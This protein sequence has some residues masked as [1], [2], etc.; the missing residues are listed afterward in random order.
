MSDFKR[1]TEWSPAYNHVAEGNGRHCM[2][3]LRARGLAE[4]GCINVGTSTKGERDGRWIFS[5]MPSGRTT[6]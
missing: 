6:R 1:I 2:E 3:V 5:G 4:G